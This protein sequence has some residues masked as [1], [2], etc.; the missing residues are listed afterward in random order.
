MATINRFT[1]YG[2]PAE[3]MG[4]SQLDAFR[5][6]IEQCKSI[7]GTGVGL[8]SESLI[9]L[10]SRFG[11]FTKLGSHHPDWLLFQTIQDIQRSFDNLA[12]AWHS[13]LNGFGAFHAHYAYESSREL[14]IYETALN[15]YISFYTNSA[16]RLVESYY[17]LRRVDSKY[18]KLVNALV[19]EVFSDGIEK[20]FIKDLRNVLQHEDLIN[21]KISVKIVENEASDTREASSS[22]QVKTAPLLRYKKWKASSKELLKS[23]EE[24]DLLELLNAYQN[25][26]SRVFNLF[27][28]RCGFNFHAGLREIEK[29]E[30]LDRFGQISLGRLLHGLNAVFKSEDLIDDILES[31]P[32][33]QRKMLRLLDPKSMSFISYIKCNLDPFNLHGDEEWKEIHRRIL[34]SPSYKM[35]EERVRRRKI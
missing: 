30:Y 3:S 19:S 8:S 21:F 17:H 33:S 32:E 29:L 31:M 11:A 34:S 14:E 25:N 7:W 23:K 24:I 20:D 10:W 26:S 13:C 16:A 9:R 5:R 18:E 4:S 35:E 28:S 22:L 15:R 1:E 12:E 6:E 27:F 2:D